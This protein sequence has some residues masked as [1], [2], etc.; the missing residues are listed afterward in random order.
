VQPLQAPRVADV[1]VPH[2]CS[3]DSC[4]CYPI[5]VYRITF[6]LG[7]NEDLLWFRKSEQRI[8]VAG[9]KEQLTHEPL[10]VTPNRKP[11]RTNPIAAWGIRLE[12]YRVFY[13]VDVDNRIV[14]VRAV[15]YKDH[16]E[17]FVRGVKVKI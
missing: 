16:N 15:G 10:R 13:D 11:L 14:T 7:A 5:R 12:E 4:W 9:A 6:T 2:R 8:I 1:S 17:L 3:R